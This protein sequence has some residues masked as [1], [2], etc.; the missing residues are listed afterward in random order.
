MG[1][2]RIWA[3]ALVAATLAGL[4]AWAIDEPF[5]AHYKAPLRRVVTLGYASFRATSADTVAASIKNAVIAYA[6]LGGLVG[7]MLGVAGGLARQSLYAAT[8]AGGIGLLAGACLTAAVSVPVL[9]GYWAHF[10]DNP[11][12][13]ELLVPLL[14]HATAWAAVGAAGGLALALGAA[15]G[16]AWVVRSMLGGLLG[17]IVGAILYEFVGAALFPLDK[18]TFPVSGSAGSRLL[19][20]LTVA[21]CVAVPAVWGIR[22]TPPGGRSTI[23]KGGAPCVPGAD[24]P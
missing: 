24:S 7:V 22:S 1:R 13:E 3:L 4:S 21:L 12:T 18:T 9:F 14:T 16:R 5:H 15:G 2:R 20:R 11:L 6:L 8:V 10:G 19:A 23:N 17:A